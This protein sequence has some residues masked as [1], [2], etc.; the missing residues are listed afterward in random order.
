MCFR[1]E[2]RRVAAFEN[3]MIDLMNDMRNCRKC[4][5]HETRKCVVTFKGA[6]KK[7]VVLIVGE[8]PG[9]M[10]DIKGKPFVGASGKLLDVWLEYLEIEEY[11]MTNVV[12]CRP[13]RN[14]QPYVAE[15]NACWPFLEETIGLLEPIYIIAVGTTA[16]ETLK[17]GKIE[18]PVIHIVHPAYGAM[19]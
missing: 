15:K 8:A 4:K 14:R 6:I 9:K 18:L 17:W 3:C 5:L 7:G 11:H 12:R 19:Y 16:N 1:E 13:P 2:R 10:E